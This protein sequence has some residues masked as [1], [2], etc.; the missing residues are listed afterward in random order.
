MKLMLRLAFVGTRYC[1]YQTQ[2]DRLTVQQTLTEAASRLFGFSCD[3]TGCSRTD[4]GVHANDFCVVINRKGEKGLETSIPLLRIPQAFATVLPTD[5]AVNAAEWVSEEFH[6]RYDVKYKEYVYRIWNAPVMNPFYADLAW[7]DPRSISEEALA[8]MKQAACAFVGTH[9]FCA[10]MATGSKVENTVRTV[11]YAD[12]TREGSMITFRVAADGFLYN[13]V[14]IMTGTLIAVAEKKIS[15]AQITEK[16]QS[17]N[18]SEMGSTAPAKG[19]YLN[20]VVYGDEKI[21]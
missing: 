7:H 4:S 5:I 9:D 8:Q 12:V 19:L 21:K 18:R 2:K 1:G 17:G 6:P 20:R 15:A 10:C 3:V 14:R 16:L 13:M 11:Y